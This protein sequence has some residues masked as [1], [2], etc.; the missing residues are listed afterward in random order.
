MQLVC[1]SSMYRDIYK[2]SLLCY[3]WQVVAYFYVQASSVGDIVIM[4]RNMSVLPHSCPLQSIGNFNTIGVIE[5]LCLGIFLYKLVQCNGFGLRL[6][7][8]NVN[9]F[10]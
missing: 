6:V 2:N 5:N 8:M 9:I 4:I 3:V 10:F 7:V 1:I